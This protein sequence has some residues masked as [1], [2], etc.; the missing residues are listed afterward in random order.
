MLLNSPNNPTGAVYPRQ[1]LE[2]I[3]Q[4]TDR[5]NFMS[6]EQSVTYGIIDKVLELEEER[7]EGV[8]RY[9]VEQEVMGQVSK[10]AF[11]RTTVTGPD[12]SE[13]GRGLAEYSKEEAVRIAGCQ[14]EAIE[15]KLGYRGR[16]VVVHRDELVLFNDDS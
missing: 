14:S 9:V 3:G 4:D 1:D 12:G 13:F 8:N 5:D 6:A 15:E 11:E 2:Q 16:A 10:I 7:R